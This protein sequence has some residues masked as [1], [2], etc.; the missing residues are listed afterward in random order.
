MNKSHTK[1]TRKLI[2]ADKDLQYLAQVPKR[3]IV[4]R[5]EVFQRAQREGS[6]EGVLGGGHCRVLG[7][8]GM[9][10]LRGIVQH[11]RSSS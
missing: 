11:I 7:L 3:D 6:R 9:V 5:P 4:A 10:E 8:R 1:G 2:H